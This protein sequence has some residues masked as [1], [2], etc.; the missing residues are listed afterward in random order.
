MEFITIDTTTGSQNYANRISANFNAPWERIYLSYTVCDVQRVF[1]LINPRP[2]Q[3]PTLHRITFMRSG[4][5]LNGEA[6]DIAVH[7]V[8]SC[9]PFSEVPVQIPVA[10][11]PGFRL[12]HWRVDF[13]GPN[14]T[15]LFLTCEDLADFAIPHGHLH[16]LPDNSNLIIR[17]IWE[18]APVEP[19]ECPYCGLMEC[20]PFTLTRHIRPP[21]RPDVIRIGFRNPATDPIN[22]IPY[23]HFDVRVTVDGLDVPRNLL[24]LHWHHRNITVRQVM[25]PLPALDDIG[26]PDWSLVTITVSRGCAEETIVLANPN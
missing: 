20:P 8:P 9:T 26:G 19:V 2:Q 24:E 3:L 10:V 23:A 4:G 25:I 12:V 16:A 7:N 13:A 1:V 11:R 6:R 5:T 14:R 22:V 18:V 15:H 21:D 17:A